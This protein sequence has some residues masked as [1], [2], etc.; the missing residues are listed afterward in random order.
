MSQR[1]R[2]IWFERMDGWFGCRPVTWEGF[3]VL[4]TCVGAVLG[5][6]KVDATLAQLGATLDLRHLAV[7][8][9]GLVVIICLI[10]M[11]VFSGPRRY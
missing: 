1:S 11:F 2:Q 6:G 8:G 9:L 5:A 10:L 3:L 7:T 4:L